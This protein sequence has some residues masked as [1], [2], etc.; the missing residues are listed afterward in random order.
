M[1]LPQL[2]RETASNSPPLESGLSSE[3]RYNQQNAVEVTVDNCQDQ[4]RKGQGAPAWFSWNSGSPDAQSWNPTARCGKPKPT[5]VTRKWFSQQSQ[6]SPLS[7]PHSPGARHEWR[8]SRGDSIPSPSRPP[9]ALW[10]FPAEAPDTGAATRPSRIPDIQS[11]W[12]K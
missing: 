9:P 3:I 2:H 4:V 1:P 8:T 12:A 7:S 10:V 6:L 5:E 11:L